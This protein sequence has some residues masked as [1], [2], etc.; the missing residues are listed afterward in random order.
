MSLFTAFF[1]MISRNGDKETRITSTGK[2]ISLS[3][4]SNE[5]EQN[6]NQ[7]RIQTSTL[8]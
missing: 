2:K 4:F 6:Q 8:G 3:F 7:R 5:C 1:S